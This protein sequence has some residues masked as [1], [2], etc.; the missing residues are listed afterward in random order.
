MF[1]R[2]PGVC[3]E[4]NMEKH[5]QSSVPN[6]A[7]LILFSIEDANSSYFIYEWIFGFNDMMNSH[8]VVPKAS[9]LHVEQN[10]FT[11]WHVW[12]CCYRTVRR[13]NRVYIIITSNG[14]IN[15]WKLQE[16]WYIVCNRHVESDNIFLLALSIKEKTN[17]VFKAYG[18]CII[19]EN[20]P[21]NN[22]YMSLIQF[23]SLIIC[24]ISRSYHHPLGGT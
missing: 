4:M 13:K 9:A 21:S 10:L 2:N 8:I 24:F 23:P 19:K 14:L 18:I 1:L 3:P 12:H 5:L 6:L 7:T 11:K 16:K 15:T 20:F 17:N 22:N